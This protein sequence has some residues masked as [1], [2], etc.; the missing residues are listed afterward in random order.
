MDTEIKKYKIYD[1]DYEIVF[2]NTFN[3]Y[4]K[5]ITLEVYW[6]NLIINFLNDSIKTDWRI[7]HINDNKDIILNLTNFNKSLWIWTSRKIHILNNVEWDKK[8]YLAI[9]SQSINDDIDFL[10][11]IITFYIK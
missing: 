2:S 5:K 6:F 3:I 7:E 9:H 8:L 1:W 11:V 4:E 10:Q